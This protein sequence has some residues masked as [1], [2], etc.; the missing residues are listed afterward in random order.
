M[1][2]NNDVTVA[3]T[4]GQG[5]SLALTKYDDLVIISGSRAVITNLGQFTKKR[6]DNLCE[7][8]QRLAIHVD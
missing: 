2:K 8:I 6:A 3:I 5:M 7:F 4:I 1:S